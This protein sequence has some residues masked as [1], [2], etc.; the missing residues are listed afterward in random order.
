MS[1]FKLAFPI[2][3]AFSGIRGIPEMSMHPEILGSFH[4]FGARC[5]WSVNA[6]LE[7]V[8]N[9][10]EPPLHSVFHVKSVPTPKHWAWAR[11]ISK[12]DT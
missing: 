6:E 1:V 3:D 5:R 12:S 4:R 8:R 2:I 10:G 7:I 11:W 9:I